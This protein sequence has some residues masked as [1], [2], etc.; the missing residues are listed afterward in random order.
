MK[1]IFVDIERCLGCKGCEIVCTLKH[2]KSGNLSG[3]IMEQPPPQSR[4]RVVSFEV[5][6]LPVQCR[7]CI[8]PACRDACISGAIEIENDMVIINKEKCVHCYSCVM[9][10]PLGIIQIDKRENIAIKCNFCPDEDIPPCVKSCPT[11]ALYY[12][13]IDDF[14][15]KQKKRK[16]KCN[17]L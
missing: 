3:A 13:E 6:S 5:F 17:T 10:C 16:E 7:H 12:G 14:I 2:S 9:A 11:K 1:R 15:K 4:I 8:D